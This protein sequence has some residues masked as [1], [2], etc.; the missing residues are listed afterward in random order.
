MVSRMICGPPAPPPT[1]GLFS[2]ESYHRTF[3]S[4]PAAFCFSFASLAFCSSISLVER[5]STPKILATSVT[6]PQAASMVAGMLPS[7][8]LVQPKGLR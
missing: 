2:S 5:S 8:S 4:L 1:N 7:P 6:S 3:L